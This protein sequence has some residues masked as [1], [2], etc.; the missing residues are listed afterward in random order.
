MK[1]SLHEQ[2]LSQQ[3]HYQKELAEAAREKR[4][5]LSK[6]DKEKT[7]R[8]A[9]VDRVTVSEK[10]AQRRADQATSIQ[11]ELNKE[12]K[13]SSQLEKQCGLQVEEVLR[14]SR[15][16]LTQLRE[17]QEKERVLSVEREN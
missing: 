12:K 13:R 2:I 6:L 1:Q 10:Q 17:A 3:S 14:K 4:E 9:E 16:E 15:E 5:L 11:E 8:K 7:E